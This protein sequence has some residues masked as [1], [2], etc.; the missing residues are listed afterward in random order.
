MAPRR[1]RSNRQSG[2]RSFCYAALWHDF[3]FQL[4]GPFRGI[5]VTRFK[6]RWGNYWGCINVLTWRF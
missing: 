2:Q 1:F 3:I 5:Y 4:E 6:G